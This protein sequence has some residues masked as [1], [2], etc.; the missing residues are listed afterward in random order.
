MEMVSPPELRLDAGLVTLVVRSMFPHRG[1]PPG[2]YERT[3]TAIVDSAREDPRIAAQLQQGLTELEAV[4]FVCLDDHARLEH[5]SQIAGTA[6]FET[7]RARATPCFYGD[8][9]V[10]RLLGY[11]R[12]TVARDGYGGRGFDAPDWLPAARTGH[13]A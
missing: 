13:A 8:P 10:W 11:Q 5:L 1:F 6:F 3:A 2:P 9:E 12:P 7:I 4:E